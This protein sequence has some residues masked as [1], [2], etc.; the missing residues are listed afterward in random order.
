MK[1]DL[2]RKVVEIALMTILLLM[3]AT[4]A[5]LLMVNAETPTTT[6]SVVPTSLVIGEEGQSLPESFTINVTVADVADLFA[7]QTLI[8]YSARILNITYVTLANETGHVFENKNASLHD[9]LI[10][11]WKKTLSNETA[12]DFSNPIGAGWL[13]E[14]EEPAMPTIKRRYNITG[15]LDSDG[16]GTL[17]RSDIICIEP[18]LPI[19]IEYYYVDRII[20]WEHPVTDVTAVELDISMARILY[21]AALLTPFDTFSG[22]GILF[23][24]TFEAIRPG[25]SV[26]NF[27]AK[28]TL[29]FNSTGIVSEPVIPIPCELKGGSVTVLGIPREV[30]PAVIREVFQQPPSAR[31]I[32]AASALIIMIVGLVFAL[33]WRKTGEQYK[34]DYGRLNISQLHVFLARPIARALLLNHA[35]RHKT[36]I[37]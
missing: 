31:D 35:Q 4:D 23:R 9:P 14:V 5:I 1:K 20:T 26:L 10:E 22:S 3:P 16:S 27:S 36:T 29:L 37:F 13:G 30:T 17:T 12:V 25:N 19:F 2:L 28:E 33:Q 32:L 34:D 11:N 21:G 8:W 18:N 6:V 24:I 15:W 7:W